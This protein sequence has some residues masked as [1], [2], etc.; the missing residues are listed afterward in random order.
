YLRDEQTGEVWSPALRPSGR[1]A[2]GG[3]VLVLH[4]PGRTTFSR[5]TGPLVQTLEIFVDATD[6]VKFSRLT[7][8]NASDESRALTVTAYNDWWLG[9]P[10]EGHERHVVTE[11]AAERS[12]VLATN[13]YRDGMPDRTAFLAC[14]EPVVSATGD[15]RSFIGR[16]GTLVAP[17]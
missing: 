1:S 4:A 15:R 14:S 17:A 5:Q 16:N 9:P 11:I 8:R 13:R 7:I 10:R 3:R 2:S 12:A 6:P